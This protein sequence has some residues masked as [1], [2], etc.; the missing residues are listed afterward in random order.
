MRRGD[1]ERGGRLG[2]RSRPVLPALEILAVV[3]RNADAAGQ[4]AARTECCAQA[5]DG[6]EREDHQAADPFARLDSRSLGMARK[7]VALAC[8]Q[9][10]QSSEGGCCVDQGLLGQK[11]EYLGLDSRPLE[12]GVREHA[13]PNGGMLKRAPVFAYRGTGCCI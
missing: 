3:P 5:A 1:E 2:L 12:I 13:R 8:G 4:A 10:G 7:Q 11:G 9:M 6:Q